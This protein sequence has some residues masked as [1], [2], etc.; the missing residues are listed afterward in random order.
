MV[1]TYMW[2][3]ANIPTTITTE[4]LPYLHGLVISMS[5]YCASFACN[6]FPVKPIHLLN[7]EEGLKL[8]MHICTSLK[9][10]RNKIDDD[11]LLVNG[12]VT[13][14]QQVKILTKISHDSLG[15]RHA[16]TMPTGAILEIINSLRVRTG[17]DLFR[18]LH[19]TQFA[20]HIKCRIHS[21]DPFTNMV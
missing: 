21:V 16:K 2:F 11:I 3:S 18:L 19:T 20:L 15:L 10:I 12:R 7:A 5:V 13:D 4:L 1:F 8:L 9:Y 6:I 17:N 14:V